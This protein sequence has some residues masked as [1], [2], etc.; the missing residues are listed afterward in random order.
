[1]AKLSV[2]QAEA[3]DLAAVAAAWTKLQVLHRSLGLAFTFPPD[4]AEQWLASFQRTLGRFS[5]LWVIGPLGQPDAFLLARIKQSP[6]F[7]GGVQVGEISDLYV[8]NSLRGSG[9]GTALAKTAMRKFQELGLHSVEVQ[10]L[11]GNESGLA[12]W[13]KLG[14]AQD[15]S[16]VRKVLKA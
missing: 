2:R 4:A 1:M 8:A 16:L 7:L 14:F 11:A 15:L 10:V 13:V 9:A 3:E 6:A 12:F 5:F